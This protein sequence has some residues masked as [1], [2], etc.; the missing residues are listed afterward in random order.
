MNETLERRAEDVR[1]WAR[2]LPGPVDLRLV[3]AEDERTAPLE[4]FLSDLAALAPGVRVAEESGGPNALP[5]LLI[6]NAWTCHLV[7]EGEELDPFLGLLTRVAAGESGLPE[8]LSEKLRKVAVPSLMEIFVTTACPNCPAVMSRLAPFPLANPLIGV[9]VVDG[10]RFPELSQEHRIRAVPTVLLGDGIRFTGQVRAEEVADELL[11]GDPACMGSEAFA[12]MIQAGDAE[13]LAVM[14]LQRKEVFPGVLDLLAGELFSLRLGAMVAMETIGE[15]DP[16]LAK[17]ALESLWQRMD[18]AHPSAR[19]DIVYLIG[20]YGD[21]G[22]RERLQGLL[23]T[24]P[25]DDLREAVEEALESL[26]G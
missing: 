14:M 5:S 23:E 22:W 16:D 8:G 12:R 18:G 11:R 25:P 26:G 13:G 6:D 4:A 9:R 17:R 2:A 1:A 3:R 19:G 7:P 10:L 24:S 20:E 15:E 21:A